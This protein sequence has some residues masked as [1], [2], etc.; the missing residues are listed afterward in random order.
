MFL[1]FENLSDVYA[2]EVAKNLIYTCIF[3]MKTKT[4]VLNSLNSVNL[5]LKNIEYF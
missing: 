5:E 2:I 4:R 3:L 1:K